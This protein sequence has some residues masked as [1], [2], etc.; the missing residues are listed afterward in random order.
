MMPAALAILKRESC[1]FLILPC[2]VSGLARAIAS[3]KETDTTFSILRIG[4]NIDHN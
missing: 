2:S 3:A 1:Y 4:T